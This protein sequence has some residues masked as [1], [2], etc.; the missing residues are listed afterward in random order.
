MKR[1]VL[2]GIIVAALVFTARSA[3]AGGG[4]YQGG[5][6][7]I[8]DFVSPPVKGLV[9]LIYNPFYWSNEYRGDNGKKLAPVTATKSYSVRDLLR[10]DATVS[11]DVNVDVF[12][13]ADSP[14]LFYFS[15]MK[16]FGA[17]YACGVAPSYNYIRTKLTADVTGT[18]KVNGR[19]VASSSRS[20]KLEDSDSGFGDLMARPVML[21]WSGE[22]YDLVASYSFYAPTG[23][24]DPA[25]LANVGLGYWSHEISLGGLYYFDKTKMTALLC[26]AT[27]EINT[28]MTGQDVYP[29]ENI[30]LEYGVEHF[31]YPW[32]EV[33]LSGSSEFQVTDDFGSQARNKSNDLMVHS[34]G[35]EFDLWVIPD[36]VSL[37]GRYF[38]QYYA[39]NDLIGQGANATVRVLF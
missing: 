5:Y 8:R 24:Y 27:Y 9:A 2:T 29:G 4:H 3:F 38:Y 20:I 37:V 18:L 39:E 19:E 14:L 1:A 23:R 26:N 17:K 30:I 16:I 33:A 31:F 11:A 12:S 28:R 10:I 15:D 32:F 36:K 34:A 7:N 35:G 21:D 22:R 25:A 6:V 13:Y